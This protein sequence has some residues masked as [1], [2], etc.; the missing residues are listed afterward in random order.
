MI[1]LCGI[2]IAWK[3]CSPCSLVLG[4]LG[5]SRVLCRLRT[6]VTSSDNESSKKQNPRRGNRGSNGFRRR[7]RRVQRDTSRCHALVHAFDSEIAKTC[8]WCHCAMCATTAFCPSRKNN[9]DMRVLVEWPD[10]LRAAV[11]KAKALPRP[12]SGLY[13]VCNRSALHRRRVQ[14]H[15]EPPA[16]SVE[17]R[18]Q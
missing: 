3:R 9:G 8:W 14:D 5:C 10:A 6:H 12:V 4:V 1:Q 18:G 13:L 7:S 16:S 2:F 11:A 15:V 17:G